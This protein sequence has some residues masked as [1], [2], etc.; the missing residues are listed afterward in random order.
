M[1]S[2]PVYASL[3]LSLCGLY[4]VLAWVLITD[5]LFAITLSIALLA[6]LAAR[7]QRVA[8]TLS[9]HGRVLHRARGAAGGLR[10]AFAG[11]DWWRRRHSSMSLPS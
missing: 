1:Q 6:Y 2:T 11:L 9:Y 3:A 8:E 5:T 4:I 10:T 7:E